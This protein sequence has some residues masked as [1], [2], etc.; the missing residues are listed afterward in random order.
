VAQ[1]DISG[2]LPLCQSQEGTVSFVSNAANKWITRAAHLAGEVLAAHADDVDRKARWPRESIAALA[3]A[4]FLGLTVPTEFGGAGEGPRTFAAV[5]TAFAEQC[6]STAMIY[7]MH[8][9]AVQV[10]A[11]AGSLPQRASLLRDAAAGRHLS[12]L[13]FSEKGSRSHFWSPVSQAATDGDFYRISAE[14]SFATS[15][16][17]ADSYV[18]STRAAGSSEPLA[19]TLY[20]IPRDTPGVTIG[21]PWNGLGLRGNCSA[22]MRLVDVRVPAAHRVSGEVDGLSTMLNVVLPWFQLGSTAVYVGISRAATESIRQHLLASKFEHLGQALASL[23]TLRARLG[24]MR[25][26]VDTQQ[27]FLDHVAGL[28][29]GPEP[30]P[31]LALLESKAAAAEAALQVTD[32]ALRTGGGA[33][34]GGRLSVERNFRDA[35]AGAVMAPTTDVLYDFVAKSLLDLPL[36]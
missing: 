18:I 9:G 10:I 31:M 5:M 30:A 8:I 19:S 16:G 4:G 15:A 33:A 22:A 27:A 26:T 1:S 2:A 25:V 35:R 17:Q 14:K 29:E 13:A 23:P 21:P 20:F 12:T 7:L 34:F 36:L 28:M 6:A 3:E 32:L 11:G 24:Q